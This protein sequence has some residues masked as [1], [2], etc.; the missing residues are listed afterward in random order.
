MDSIRYE[1]L[2]KA[3]VA[4]KQLGKSSTTIRRMIA[5]NRLIGEKNGAR[6][7][8]NRASLEQFI[9]T[10]DGRIDQTE[11]KPNIESDISDTITELIG[12]ELV[13]L[14]GSLPTE[15]SE[16][17]DD[18]AVF[19]CLKGHIQYDAVAFFER[20]KDFPFSSLSI[21]ARCVDYERNDYIERLLGRR[22]RVMHDNIPMIDLLG[23]NLWTIIK[24]YFEQG[25]FPE[26]PYI[27]K[28]ERQIFRDDILWRLE[29]R[30]NAASVRPDAFCF[31]FKAIYDDWTLM[32]LETLGAKEA[33]GNH[34]WENRSANW[35]E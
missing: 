26:D 24:D 9:E 35:S 12:T 7:W 4:A 5:D 17:G 34:L 31:P 25:Y 2:I 33:I 15:T 21:L 13:P 19:G 32:E 11:L 16:T 20:C 8:V 29:I 28:S 1:N 30:E 3:S 14:E 22:F 27:Q 6:Y 23:D 18:T 10:G